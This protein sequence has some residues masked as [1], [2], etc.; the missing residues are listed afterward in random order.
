M[1]NAGAGALMCQ[2]SDTAHRAEISAQDDADEP[3]DAQ[4]ATGLD[5]DP[6]PHVR[7]HGRAPSFVDGRRQDVFRRFAAQHK[8]QR[9][10]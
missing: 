3:A 6:V 9:R 4:E 5:V 7:G 8:P 10:R 1:R 2:P